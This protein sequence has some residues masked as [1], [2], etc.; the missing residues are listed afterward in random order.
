MNRMNTPFITTLFSVSS[1]HP[2]KVPE[3]YEGIFPKGT[4]PVH[5]CIGYTD[6]A[7]KKFFEKVK[8]MDWYENTLFV[9]TADHSSF[10]YFESSKNSLD[11]YSIPLLFFA[12]GDDRLRGLDK[13][14][15]QH[16]DIMPS[17]LDYLG[18]PH[19]YVSFGKSVLN[20]ESSRFVISYFDGNYQY[21]KGD[22]L[23]HFDGSQIKGIYDISSDRMMK[24]NL[25]GEVNIAKIENECKAFLQQYNNR[26]IDDQFSI[27]E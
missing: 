18:Y 21:M 24:N 14:T 2:F 5:Q 15:A 20:K 13:N 27:R 17:V 7:L 26:M 19:S 3:E 8:K 25:L 11:R 9:I 22:T 1:H 23:I 16:I 6:M 10:S 12:P 4:L